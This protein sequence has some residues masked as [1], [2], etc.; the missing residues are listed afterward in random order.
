[1]SPAKYVNVLEG[2]L[3]PD[4]TG[5]GYDTHRNHVL[6]SARNVVHMAKRL[7]EIINE[8]GEADPQ[9]LDLDRHTVLINTEFG[10]TPTRE[11]TKVNPDGSGTDHWPW[12][13]VVI[14]FG[15]PFDEERRGIVGSIGE[16][17]RA[18]ESIS[19]TEHRAAMLQMMGAWPFAQ[20]SFAVSE[21]RGGDLA[22]ELESALWLR[23]HVLGYG[24]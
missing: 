16:D 23:E 21:V 24:S 17:A 15:G 19:P 18:I 10:R 11:F 1:M 9:K 14:A 4:P 7:T 13:Y 2:G 20:E 5:L 8:P 22:S 6:W 12:G 3:Y